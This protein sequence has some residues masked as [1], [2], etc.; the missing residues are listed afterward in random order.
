MGVLQYAAGIC[1]DAYEPGTIERCLLEQF[2]ESSEHEH[3]TPG[4]NHEQ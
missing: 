3:A 2:A 4:E 1:M